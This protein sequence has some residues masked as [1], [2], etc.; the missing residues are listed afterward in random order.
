MRANTM[1]SLLQTLILGPLVGFLK[2]K[3]LGILAAQAN[4]ED[5]SA[6]VELIECKAVKL[7]IDRRYALQE[8]PEAVRYV[9][10]GHAQG[11]VVICIE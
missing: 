6:I 3:K 9:G 1:N 5:L 11:K 4:G 10:E 2:K 7:I 8:V